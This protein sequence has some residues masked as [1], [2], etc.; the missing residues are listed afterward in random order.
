VR[1]YAITFLENK[2]IG[3]INRD[4]NSCLNMLKIVSSWFKEKKRPEYLT[5]HSIKDFNLDF[6]NP[7]YLLD[8]KV[9]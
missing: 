4:K 6:K 9:K 1:C 8:K 5:K 3:C 2:R 7:E